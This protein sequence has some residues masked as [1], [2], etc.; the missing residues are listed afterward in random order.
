MKLLILGSSGNIGKSLICREVFFPRFES[1]LIIEVETVNK[2]SKEMKH[3]NV[4]EFKSGDDFT[5]LYL[6][7]MENENVIVDVGASNLGAFWEQMQS[8]AGIDSLFDYFIVP[9]VPNDKEMTDTAKTIKFLQVQGISDE[10]IKVIFNRVRSSVK[11]DFAI[12]LSLPFA[13]DE[14]LAIKENTALYNDLGILRKTIKDIYNPNLD[15]YK[16]AI[17][18]EK[19]NVKKLGLIKMDLANRQAVKVKET[20]DYIFESVTGLKSAWKDE[21]NISAK[22][23]AS[24]AKI[25]PKEAQESDG[26]HPD[27]EEL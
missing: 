13:F 19:D 5:T 15:S 6:K 2:G 12:L 4:F 26:T 9:T 11:S 18:D 3:L 14:S 8:F 22:G 25:T 21:G 7:L 10:R 27:D 20:M 1:P 24:K 17:L 16:S 23:T